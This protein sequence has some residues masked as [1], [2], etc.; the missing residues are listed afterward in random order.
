MEVGEGTDKKEQPSLIKIKARHS[1]HV[2]LLF[3][4]FGFTKKKKEIR[5]GSEINI[6]AK[7]PQGNRDDIPF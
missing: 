2:Q 1:P 5:I 7:M 4:Y 6:Q 3:Q